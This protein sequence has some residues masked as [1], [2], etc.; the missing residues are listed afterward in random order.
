MKNKHGRVGVKRPTNYQQNARD[1]E[2]G[3]RAGFRSGQQDE[4]R[5]LELFLRTRTGKK[6]RAEVEARLI[7]LQ[8]R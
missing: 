4:M 8:A 5:S 2:K 7:A 3:W 1:F 6:M